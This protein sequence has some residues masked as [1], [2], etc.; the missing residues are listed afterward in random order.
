MKKT[1]AGFLVMLSCLAITVSATELSENESLKS[2]KEMT[3]ESIFTLNNKDMTE[4]SAL[5]KSYDLQRIEDNQIPSGITPLEFNTVEEAEA[6][7]EKINSAKNM[8][9]DCA[10]E[11]MIINNIIQA[12][13][14][15]GSGVMSKTV[16]GTNAY[17]FQGTATLNYKWYTDN[18]NGD[19]RFSSVTGFSATYTG[20]TLFVGYDLMSYSSNIIDSGRTAGVTF[21][22]RTKFY[23]VIKGVGEIYS[24]VDTTY[25]EFY[26]SAI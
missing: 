19:K 3:D 17:L 7:L 18:T 1:I 15:T 12:A 24:T 21:T 13:A 16:P 9:V 14:A 22:G 5:E 25:M 20:V 6:F 8:H 4:I 23:L 10:Q 26:S 11:E 2:S